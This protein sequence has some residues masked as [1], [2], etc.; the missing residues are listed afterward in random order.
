MIII[1]AAS[2]LTLVVSILYANALERADR[3]K[4]AAMVVV[5]PTLPAAIAIPTAHRKR[6]GWWM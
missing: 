6:I 3:L 4:R 5:S 2:A 1:F